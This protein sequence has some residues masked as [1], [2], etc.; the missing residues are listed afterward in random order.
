[1][2]G[3]TLG[4]VDGHRSAERRSLAMHRAIA[5]RLRADPALI[6]KARARVAAWRANGEVHTDYVDAWERLLALCLD[7]L[8]AQ[9]VDPGEHAR[10]LRQVS[11]FAG[12]LSARERWSIL[13]GVA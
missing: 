8:C 6:D 13:Q 5:D 7:E 11:P 12:V 2:A 1:L 9:L 10:A 3:D 4:D